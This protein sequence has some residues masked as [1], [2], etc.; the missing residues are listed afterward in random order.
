[1]NLIT[2]A[3]G[4]GVVWSERTGR[5]VV[6]MAAERDGDRRTRCTE[7]SVGIH[8]QDRVMGEWLAHVP[9][10]GIPF[11]GGHRLARGPQLLVAVSPEDLRDGHRD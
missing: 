3:L 1:M 6:P 11:R 4:C 5:L 2:D 10:Q 7:I 9:R 8:P